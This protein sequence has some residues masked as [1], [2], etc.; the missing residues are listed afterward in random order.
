LL[1]VSI[2]LADTEQQKDGLLQ[3]GVTNPFVLHASNSSGAH[4]YE[5]CIV[6]MAVWI[7]TIDKPRWLLFRSL[8][9]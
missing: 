5:N 8:C 3:V 7:W 6:R 2:V 4:C 1:I 9:W